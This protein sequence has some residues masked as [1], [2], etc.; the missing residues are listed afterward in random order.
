MPLGDITKPTIKFLGE[1]NKDFTARRINGY[2][3]LEDDTLDENKKSMKF[4]VVND[5]HKY[6]LLRTANRVSEELGIF[7]P[8]AYPSIPKEGVNYSQIYP[9]ITF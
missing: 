7:S 6:L 3:L 2:V 1:I 4:L 8:R 9:Q 5:N